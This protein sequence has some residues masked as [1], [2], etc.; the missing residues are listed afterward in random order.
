MPLMFNTLRSKLTMGFLPLVIILIGLGLWAIAMFYRLGGNIDVILRENYRSVLAVERMKEGLERMD[1]AMAFGI[2]AWD[3]R[4]QPQFDTNKAEF[5]RQL[6]VEQGN[7]T[8]P[9]E[10][11]LVDGLTREYHEYLE[12]AAAYFGLQ[13]A[14]P[15]ERGEF[16]FSRLLPKFDKLKTLENQI[17]L[18]NQRNMEEMNE[19]ALRNASTSIRLMVGALLV[20]VVLAIA[21]QRVLSRLILEPIMLVTGA[22]RAVSQGNLNQVVPATT[23]DELGELAQTFNTMARTI[24]E[25]REAG[26]VRLLRAQKTAQATIDSF[27]DPVIVLDPA[28]AVERANPAAQRLLQATPPEDGGVSPWTAPAP[29][30]PHLEAVLGGQGDYLPVSL[31]Q[32]LFLR[33]GNQDRYFLPKV[34]RIRSDSGELLGAAVSLLDVTKFQLVDQLKNDMISTVSHELK[35]PLTSLQMAV[36][37]LL[38]EAVGPLTPKQIELLLTARQD[39][40][41]LLAMINDLLDLTRI[42]QGQVALDIKPQR[43]GDLV[44][45]AIERFSAQAADAGIELHSELPGDLPPVLVDRDRVEHVFDNLLSNALRHTDRGGKIT[46]GARA[47]DSEVKFEVEDTGHGIPEDSLPRVFDRF[48]R[49]PNGNRPGGAGLGLAIA[50][51]ILAAH[52]GQIDVR[53]RVGEGTT[54]WFT[55]PATRDPGVATAKRGA[56][57]DFQAFS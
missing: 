4:S 11:E 9:G 7:V 10:R 16:Y 52:G 21:S 55:L 28:G 54:F 39:S 14:A 22:A 36:H 37:L 35:T 45:G 15:S 42:E 44:R 6:A 12:L 30:R 43:P 1:S 34:L 25:F 24:R 33:D 32:A 29:L 48:F 13:H 19:T 2:N 57:Q 49:V 50:R 23:N 5:E 20:A 40:E 26:T 47:S 41:R 53:S 3:K 56:R 27:P 46:L 18:L 17:L 8:V 31:D 51:E 38:E